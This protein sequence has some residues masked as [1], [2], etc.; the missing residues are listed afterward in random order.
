M[1]GWDVEREESYEE[2]GVWKEKILIR[3]HVN[4]SCWAYSLLM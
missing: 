2:E 3:P 4:S 1:R